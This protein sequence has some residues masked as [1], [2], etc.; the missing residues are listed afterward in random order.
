M[1]DRT[2]DGRD[3]SAVR[4][5]IEHFAMTF[6]ELGF[7][8]MAARVLFVIMCA[9]EEALTAAQIAERLGISPAAVS[10]AVRYLM[11]IQML[12]REPVPGSRRDRYSLPSDAWYEVSAL[13]G[14]AF[15]MFSKLAA[16]GVNALG[17]D[18][19]GPGARLAQMRDYFEFIHQEM[20][21]LLD[22]WETVKAERAAKEGTP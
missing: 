21:S 7:P 15:R 13:K 14:T 20:P 8:R 4:Q 6:G 16:E 5:F 1:T 12:R 19:T 22:R 3:E 17:G 2:E 11:Q 9:E 18:S 10:G